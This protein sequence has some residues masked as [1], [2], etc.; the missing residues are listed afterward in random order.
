ML[1]LPNTFQYWQILWILN[2]EIMKVCK[3]RSLFE[4]FETAE[5]F[6]ETDPYENPILYWPTLSRM[7][8]EITL[9]DFPL[10][11]GEGTPKT[12]LVYIF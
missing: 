1:K 2:E 12:G 7:S 3:S 8:Q 9:E 10:I 5:E 4:S 11:V 6:I